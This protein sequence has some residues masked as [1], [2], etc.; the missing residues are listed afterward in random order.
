MENYSSSLE[1]YHHHHQEEEEYHSTVSTYKQR[2]DL[3]YSRAGQTPGY[4]APASQ[5][6]CLSYN[7]DILTDNSS[8]SGV[9]ED[10]QCELSPLSEPS[11]TSTIST[12]SRSRARKRLTR[13]PCQKKRGGVSG[14]P[15]S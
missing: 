7:T 8:D 4:P 11:T 3:A 9:P 1:F 13:V 6:E 15:Q 10:F 2:L 14:Q 12:T 5:P